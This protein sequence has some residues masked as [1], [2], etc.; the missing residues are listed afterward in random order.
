MGEVFQAHDEPIVR[1]INNQ[2]MRDGERSRVRVFAGPP[3]DD[4]F[5][6]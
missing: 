5:E 6:P 1:L 3:L 4:L 2:A